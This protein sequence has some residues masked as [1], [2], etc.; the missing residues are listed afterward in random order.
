MLH[1]WNIY[2]HLPQNGP[3]NVGTY[4]STMEHLGLLTIIEYWLCLTIINYY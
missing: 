2:L 3:K 1:V 4:S